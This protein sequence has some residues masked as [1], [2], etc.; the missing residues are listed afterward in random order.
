MPIIPKIGGDNGGGTVRG[1]AS[2]LVGSVG[3]QIKGAVAREASSLSPSNLLGVAQRTIDQKTGGLLTAGKELLGIASGKS[4][5][6]AGGVV[7]SIIGGA[8]GGA[9]TATT[10]LSQ[11]GGLSEHLF[12]SIFPVKADGTQLA[13]EKGVLVPGVVGPATDVQFE[14]TLN[15]QSPFEQSGPESKAPTIMAMLQTGQIATVANALQAALQDKLPAVGELTKDVAGKAES[16]AKNL[17]GRTGITKLNS[18]QVFSGM[19]PL[20]IT[21]QLHLRAVS[22]P[23][24]EVIVPYQ[25]L[26]EWAFPQK[27]AA[28]GILSE[29]V[30]SS[31]GIVNA[32]FPSEA[33]QLVK[34]KFGNNTFP[35]MVIESVA[36]PLDGPMDSTGRP[37]YR[38]VQLTLATLT[39][40]DRADVAPIFSRSSQ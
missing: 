40:L 18:R 4:A 28:D 11:W 38:S 17:Q 5:G 35:L 26:L 34:F 10:E 3:S 1:A 19:P 14:A 30:T 8:A 31:D 27:L 20:R 29:M 33:P 15:W 2:A 9:D 12:A 37:I 13:D 16:W 25:T 36:N 7:S 23:E 39:A 24:S 6:G 32:M 21:M 22:D